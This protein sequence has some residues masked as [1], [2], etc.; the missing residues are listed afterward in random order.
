MKS[1][2]FL[3]NIHISR[4]ENQLYLEFQNPNGYMLYTVLNI[5]E[6]STTFIWFIL[7]DSVFELVKTGHNQNCSR[8]PDCAETSTLNSHNSQLITD[9]NV[10]L[11]AL[12]R[13]ES[14][15]VPRKI[16]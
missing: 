12:E 4:S 1:G 11:E 8:I 5:K 13:Y 3:G 6:L 10:I 7:T 14:L 15:L 16:W 2:I 9:N